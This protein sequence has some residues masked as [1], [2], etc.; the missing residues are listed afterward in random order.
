MGK[1]SDQKCFWEGRRGKEAGATG[2]SGRWRLV[3]WEMPVI[4]W[5]ASLP[6]AVLLVQVP[7]AVIPQ[8]PWP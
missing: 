6:S 4:A 8:I 2:G 1:M 7:T 3:V 5:C